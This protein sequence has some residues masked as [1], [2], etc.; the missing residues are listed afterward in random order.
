VGPRS[1]GKSAPR[2]RLGYKAAVSAAPRV[3]LALVAVQLLFGLWPVAGMAVMAEIS[4]A[5]LIGVRLLAGAPLLAGLAGLWRHRLPPARDLLSLAVLGALGVSVNQLL[6]AVG[7][8]RAGPVNAS[9]VVLLIPALVLAASAALGKERLRRARIAGVIVAL[10]GAAILLRAERLD[11]SD[12]KTGGNLMLIASAS[13]YALFIVLARPVIARLG[14]LKTTAWVFVLGAI[15]ALPL[16][17]PALARERWLEL[18]AWAFA[19]LGFVVLG[20]TVL[21]YLLNAWALRFVESSLVGAYVYLQPVVATLAAW[22]ILDL[23]PSPR[24]LGAA[25]VIVVGV[26]LS[27]GL[28]HALLARARARG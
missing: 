20:P 4:P 15:E 14:A 12:H 10:A 17:A 18:P 22:A 8:H 5:A 21:T 19:S 2:R 26:A 11:L 24:A 13:V 23:V 7:L 25:V 1:A 27:S 9:I 3:H 16:T 6:Y 28:F